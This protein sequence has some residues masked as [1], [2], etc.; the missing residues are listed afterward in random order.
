[1]NE[2]LGIATVYPP[3]VVLHI[4]H[5]STVI[6]PSI[7]DQFVL[8]D[9]ALRAELIRMTD[10]ETRTL[11]AGPDPRVPVVVASVSRLVV[12]VERFEDDQRETMSRRE[13]GVI[14]RRTSHG[15]PLRRN[16]LPEEREALVAAYFRPHHQEL[17]L[18]VDNCVQAHGSCLIIDGHS[19]PSSPLPYEFDQNPAR[20]DI[21]IGT[22]EFHTPKT[23]ADAFIGRFRRAGFSVAVNRPFTGTIV[24]LACH[25]KSRRVLSVMV[26][27]NRGIYLDEAE[28][29]LR[30]DRGD[31]VGSIRSACQ[32]ASWLVIN[33]WKDSCES[34]S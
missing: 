13:M 28:G 32:E 3:G 10:H 25:R 1:M 20:A 18:A 9:D 21:C 34:V 27:V 26:E 5:D 11:F 14:Y 2:S 22:D 24:P 29:R 6:P 8:D 4:P 15:T 31:V 17:T 33:S 19:F 16:L 30:V 12:D 7:R 23:V